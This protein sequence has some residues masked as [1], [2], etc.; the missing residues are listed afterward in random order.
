MPPPG[1]T[2]NYNAVVFGTGGDHADQ[3][4]LRAVK[5]YDVG[6]F[7]QGMVY[8]S[9]GVNGRFGLP[10]SA[11]ITCIT[12]IFY[13]KLIRST[14]SMGGCICLQLEGPLVFHRKIPCIFQGQD[15]LAGGPV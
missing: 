10:M 6:P 3:G 14:I 12:I 4:F 8:A 1:H 5:V 15:H 13:Q 2:G 9:P 7:I 11:P